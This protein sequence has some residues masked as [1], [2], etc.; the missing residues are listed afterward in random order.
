MEEVVDFELY[1]RKGDFFTTELILQF[2]Q[3]VLKLNSF[4]SLVVQVIFEP[5]LGLS[6]LLPLVFEHVLN[7][8]HSSILFPS[9]Y[10]TTV[11]LLLG[12]LL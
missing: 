11:A 7:F 3:F 8:I 5:I 6:K 1:L 12:S 10:F 2:Y 9:I 4:L